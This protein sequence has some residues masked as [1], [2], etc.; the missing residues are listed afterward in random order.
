[1]VIDKAC[2]FLADAT[3]VTSVSHT[4][5]VSDQSLSLVVRC[6]ESDYKKWTADIGRAKMTASGMSTSVSFGS[7]FGRSA[8]KMSVTTPTAS[9]VVAGTP[10]PS[11]KSARDSIVAK[12]LEISK[13][14]EQLA[15]KRAELLLLP[16]LGEADET[17][18]ALLS[19]GSARKNTATSSSS[20]VGVARAEAYRQA[21][22]RD[23]AHRLTCTSDYV[24]AGV[25]ELSLAVAD[26]VHAWYTSS[27]CSGWAFGLVTQKDGKEISG[28]F[29][30]ASTKEATAA[31]EETVGRR[32]RAGSM[33]TI[34]A[35]VVAEVKKLDLEGFAIKGKKKKILGFSLFFNGKKK[36]ST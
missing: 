12:L 7:L 20:G 25:G 19:P 18:V 1:M 31:D 28:W 14:E 5:S 16:G 6:D 11:G 26:V 24:A 36:F 2:R 17:A 3:K 34:N 30:L 32:P 8:S 13:L 15:R 23:A 10:P 4:F 29:P 35:P 9:S 21:A 22:V 33:S 27:C